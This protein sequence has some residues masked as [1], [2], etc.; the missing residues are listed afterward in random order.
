ML[1]RHS[2]QN[3]FT[4]ELWGRVIP[5]KNQGRQQIVQIVKKKYE[6][7]EWCDLTEKLKSRERNSGNKSE[8]WNPGWVTTEDQY[9]H[10]V[11]LKITRDSFCSEITSFISCIF[12]INANSCFSS[13]RDVFQ[14]FQVRGHQGF[15]VSSYGSYC[16]GTLEK[17]NWK[18]QPPKAAHMSNSPPI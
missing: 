14:I 2:F 1:P 13:S 18:L 16:S 3:L 15:F 9:L 10:H 5:L 12:P 17:Q 4:V 8:V 7:Q 6:K 11:S